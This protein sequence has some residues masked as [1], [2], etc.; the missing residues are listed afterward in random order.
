MKTLVT[1]GLG[2]L[3][4]AL[5]KA[6]VIRGD[7]VR[8]L[9][10]GS[11]GTKEKLGR[12]LKDIELIE[13]DIRDPALVHEA[14]KGTDRVCHLAAINGTGN[15]YERPAHVLDVGV[16]GM[17]NVLD[18]CMNENVRDLLVVSSSEVYHTPPVT[19][20]P[21]E[22]PLV[23]PDV[24]NPRYS[25]AGTKII[26]ELMA[27]HYGKEGGFERT[28]IVRPHNIYGPDMGFDHVIPQ[29]IMRLKE[30]SRSSTEHPLHFPIQ[31]DGTQTRAFCYIDDFI[32]GLLL[33]MEKGEHLG[34]YN[35]G[36]SD[37]ISIHD[38]V[39]KISS[40]MNLEITVA[41][42]PPAPGATTRRCPDISKARA[43]GYCPNVSFEQGL[44]QTVDWYL[45]F[46]AQIL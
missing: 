1:G 40:I 22:V 19:P 46:E 36:T 45:A 24:R 2:F 15:F 4:S 25:Y 11:R 31:G 30:L 38:L 10:D 26:S 39:M 34:T 28:R 35:L 20:T 32:A 17:V 9:D 41:P 27:L 8:I 6:L 42:G 44:A 29:F 7:T 43:L 21:E 16:K 18:A 14:V 13:G 3:G 5:S 33:V 37:E 23:I 12:A